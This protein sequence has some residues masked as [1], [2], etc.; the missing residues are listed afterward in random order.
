MPLIR[1]E[2]IDWQQQAVLRDQIAAAATVNELKTALQAL[3][4]HL[5]RIEYVG[6]EE[7]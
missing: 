3:V 4:D 6:E 1:V 5:A 7:S 2:L